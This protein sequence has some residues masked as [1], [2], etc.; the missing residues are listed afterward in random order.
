M[1]LELK[2][3]LW[4]CSQFYMGARERRR[5]NTNKTMK[6]ALPFPLIP[7]FRGNKCGCLELTMEG[8][9]W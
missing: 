5:E 6:E 4:L 2:F 1:A 7:I 3:N 8:N 9:S